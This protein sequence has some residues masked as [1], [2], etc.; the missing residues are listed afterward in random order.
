MRL[1]LLTAVLAAICSGCGKNNNGT[2]SA[3]PLNIGDSHAGGIIFYL[4]STGQHGL[5]AAPADQSTSMRFAPYTDDNGQL[6]DY[7]TMPGFPGNAEGVT[8]SE[9]LNNMLTKPNAANT[10]R[11]YD[12]G[13]FND[14]YLPNYTE[15]MEMCKISGLLNLLPQKY[16]WNIT[17][18]PFMPNYYATSFNCDNRYSKDSLAA[19]RAVRKF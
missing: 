2:P 19:V 6:F 15:F 11:S 17:G 18:V 7:S 14:W 4:D 1:I 16:Y 10:C 9:Y 5:V 12:G 13:G 3:V 8:S